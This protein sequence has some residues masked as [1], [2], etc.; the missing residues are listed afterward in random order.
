M[1]RWCCH[2]DTNGTFMSAPGRRWHE[3]CG[4]APRA[5]HDHSERVLGFAFFVTCPLAGS[6]A[7]DLVY[8]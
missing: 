5:A 8:G 3:E 4:S 6:A 1:C 7:Y 2:G